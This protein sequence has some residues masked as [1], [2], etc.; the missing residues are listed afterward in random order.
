MPDIARP[1]AQVRDSVCAMMRIVRLKP[2]HTKH[3]PAVVQFRVAFVGTAWCIVPDRFLLTAHHVL[4]EGK[5]RE[6]AD[7]FYAFTVPAN[8]DEAYCFP[9]IAFPHEDAEA[10]IAALEIGPPTAPGQHIPSAPVTF[11]HPPDGS[12]VLTIGFPSPQIEAAQLDD[13]GRFLGGGRFFLK[14]HSNTGIVSAQYAISGKWFFEFNV[15]WHHG[16]SGGPVF[17]LNPVAAFAIMQ[18]YR[19]VDTPHGI[20]PGPHRGRS[21]EA[22]RQRI[23][24]LGANVI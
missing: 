10:D 12:Q 24:Q 16:E 17:A 15:G 18:Q 21:L 1:L 4:N 3:G 13:A 11:S 2:K 22:V 14:S 6:P 19:N 7:A 5:P 8:R 9:V 20:F 23:E